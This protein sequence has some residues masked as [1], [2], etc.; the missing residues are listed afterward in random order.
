M[1][2]RE[3]Q[4]QLQCRDGL[5]LRLDLRRPAEEQALGLVVI[6]H[7]FKGF[8]NWGFFPY[9]G[10]TLATRGFVTV[11]FDFSLNGVGER[12]GE[13]DRLDLFERNTYAREIEDLEHVLSW[14]RRESP[15]PEETRRL[16]V[17]LL[18]HSR[19]ALSAIVVARED[20]AIAA[21]VTWNGISQAL[22][23]TERQLRDWEEEGKLEFLNSRTKQRMAVGFTLVEDARENARR[24][25]LTAGVKEMKA[26]HLILQAENDLAVDPQNAQTLRAGR[27]EADGCHLEMIPGTGHTWN[28]I[29]PF[30]GTTDALDRAL[31]LSSEWFTTH[32]GQ[33]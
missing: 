26:A 11:C 28:A 33:S 9:L 8:K 13:F 16:G 5:P 19:G 3:S 21:L 27:G 32:L 22:H 2:L 7:G 25:D 15:L 18:A 14:L 4:H 6:V 30:A 31:A 20:P 17:G 1:N 24:Y 12:P 29:H 23:Y 10:R